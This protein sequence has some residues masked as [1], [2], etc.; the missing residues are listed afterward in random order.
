MKYIYTCFLI[1]ILSGQVV[2]AD[3][4]E[5]CSVQI[6]M[7]ATAAKTVKETCLKY[8]KPYKIF[9]H[10]DSEVNPI[11]ISTLLCDFNFAI[12]LS[13]TPGNTN[14]LACIGHN[15]SN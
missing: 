1:L 6:E 12:V 14:H 15:V 5:T 8:T 11:F 10:I 9:A 2:L 4:N 3:I 13:D 7:G